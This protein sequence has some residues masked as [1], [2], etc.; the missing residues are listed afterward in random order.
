MDMFYYIAVNVSTNEFSKIK[1]LNKFNHL[2]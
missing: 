2:F 1:N